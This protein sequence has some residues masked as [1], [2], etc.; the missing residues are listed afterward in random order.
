MK[1]RL[2]TLLFIAVNVLSVAVFFMPLFISTSEA[3]LHSIVMPISFALV[4][5]SAVGCVVFSHSRMVS[6]SL[7]TLAAIACALGTLG[8]LL[9][10]PAGGS[11]MFFVVIICGFA[12]GSQFGQLVGMTSMF[13]SA[14]LTGGI[15]PWLG[16]QAI[17]MGLVGAAAGIAC[18]HIVREVKR[19]GKISVPV[20]AVLT[21]YAG[22]LGLLFGFIINWWSWPFLDYGNMLSFDSTNSIMTNIAHYMNFYIRTS[23]WWDAW[24]LIGNIVLMTVIG[25]PVIMALLPAREFLNPE[26]RF[27]SSEENVYLGATS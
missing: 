2:S 22:L 9:D 4:L 18:P 3:H 12:L 10:L 11:G 19:K 14:L 24:A 25:R 1:P 5:L 15:G 17:A 23:L 20:F 6:R 26:I 13:V 16:Y 7:I 21:L 8:K 27:M